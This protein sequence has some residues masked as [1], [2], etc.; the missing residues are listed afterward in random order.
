MP[1]SA[2]SRPIPFALSNQVH[3]QIQAMLPVTLIVCEGNAVRICLD[4]RRINKRMVADRMK[5]MPMHELLQTFYGAKYI[6]SLDLSSAFYRNVLSSLLG[7]GCHFTLKVMCINL[8]QF[9][10]ASRT[11]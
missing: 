5:V 6:T 1:H 3:E 8:Q 11:A 4:A 7:N 10:T 2:N 9:L